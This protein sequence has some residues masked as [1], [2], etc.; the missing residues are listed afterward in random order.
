MLR[1][2]AILAGLSQRAPNADQRNQFARPGQREPETNDVTF[3]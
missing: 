1:Y 2:L 3:Q